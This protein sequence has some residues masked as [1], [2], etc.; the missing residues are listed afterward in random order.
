MKFGR[1]SVQSRNSEHFC[2]ESGAAMLAVTLI[3]IAI[4]DLRASTGGSVES[5]DKVALLVGIDRYQSDS[6]PRLG[7]PLNDLEDV[8]QVLVTRYGF[9]NSRVAILRDSQATHA[10]IIAE[11]Y[12]LISEARASTSVVFY[13]A[14]HGSRTA[15]GEKPDGYDETIVPY[16]SRIGDVY[17]ISDKEIAGL[18][19]LL[20]RKTQNVIL[21]FDSCYSGSLNRSRDVGLRVRGVDPDTR[22]RPRDPD[23]A[24]PSGD[25]RAH[26]SPKGADKSVNYVV[27]SACLADQEAHEVTINGT[28]RGAFTYFL[29]ESLRQPGR[30]SFRD[31]IEQVQASVAARF[32]FQTP[33][34]EGSLDRRPFGDQQIAPRSYFL[35]RQNL[36]DLVFE[37]GKVHGVT[38]GS[39][40]R[41]FPPGC[42]DFRETKSIGKLRL[43]SVSA[44]SS[45][46]EILGKGSEIPDLSRAVEESHVFEHGPF[47]IHFVDL[48]QDLVQRIVSK[49]S[50][51]RN[52]LVIDDGENCDLIVKLTAEGVL[53]LD[54]SGTLELQRLPNPGGDD[55][56][57]LLDIKNWIT[58]LSS[59][60]VRNP[61]GPLDLSCR[62]TRRNQRPGMSRAIGLPEQVFKDGA[63]LEVSVTN[64]SS[65]S[66]YL[67]ILDFATDGSID[68]IYPPAGVSQKIGPGVTWTYPINAFV[69]ADR[70]RVRDVLK[71]F[72]T[73]EPVNFAPLL[74][75]TLRSNGVSDKGANLLVPGLSGQ[76]VWQTV[77]RV[78][79]V[80]AE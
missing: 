30:H 59:L 36:G 63:E 57:I 47:A 16:D 37:G 56:A 29:T 19:S 54:P 28:A 65:Q 43:A 49:L 11:F 41:V 80:Q 20:L 7:G 71:F 27:L 66:P 44:Y 60:E 52:I 15:N 77:E 74:N 31:V 23:Y 35:L 51:F 24:L 40:Y 45:E 38:S 72:F 48:S 26:L 50:G 13:F 78:F 55:S 68:Q 1:P 4:A 67:T 6:L 14:G 64:R 58:W 10:T 62:I 39:I 33:A 5:S 12:R 53:L 22:P 25:S 32:A 21:I 17:D 34:A 42:T 18:L 61:V 73:A 8:R 3:W 9:P 75:R 70:K 69:P 76:R 79:D 2:S 46:T